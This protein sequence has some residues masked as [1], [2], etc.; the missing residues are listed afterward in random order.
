MR[1]RDVKGCVWAAAL[2]MATPAAAQ[3]IAADIRDAAQNPSRAT[4]RSHAKT[5]PTGPGAE[6][7]AHPDAIRSGFARYVELRLPLDRREGLVRRRAGHV[8]DVGHRRRRGAAEL[9]EPPVR[10]HRRV[11]DER[12]R[13]PRRGG[14]R[15]RIRSRHPD[16]GQDADDAG[17]GRRLALCAPGRRPCPGRAPPRR[18]QPAPVRRRNPVRG[19]PG[20]TPAARPAAPRPFAVYGGGGLVRRR[21]PRGLRLCRLARKRSR[22]RS[23][24]SSSSAASRSRSGSG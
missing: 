3:T 7:A 23:T 1:R 6:Q 8:D 21:V 9:L 11:I 20:A 14:E 4:R 24:A 17:S 16:R 2:A 15:R 18:R 22:A 10:P 12:Y 13:Q 5:A 19:K